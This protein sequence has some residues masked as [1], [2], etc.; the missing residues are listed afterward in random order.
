MRQK[1]IYGKKKKNKFFI[2]ILM[3]ILILLV[4]ILGGILYY[5]SLIG[6]ADANGQ[7][8]I[9]EIPQ[10]YSVRAIASI[11][12]EE[13]IV[14]KDFAFLM[15]ARLG[16]VQSQLQSGKYLLSPSMSTEEIIDRLVGGDVVDERI[17]VTI[18]EGFELKMIAE[19]LEEK[20]LTN[21]EDFIQATQ[22]IDEFEYFFL[23]D[24]PKNRD[25]PLEGYLFPDTYYFSIDT[26]DQQMVRAMLDRFKD[27]FKEEY[28]ERA[29]ELGMSIDEIVILASV[30]EREAMVAADRPI[31]SG[32]FHKRLE[33]GMR[34]ESCATIQYIL[35]ERK[36][37]LLYSDLKVE[38]PY[39]T[40]KQTGLP[41]GPI[42]S[43]GEA[44]LKAT[45]YPDKTDY[46]FFVA[47]DDG[48]H[49]FTKT[50][51]EHNAAKKQVLN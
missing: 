38:S 36:P 20:G 33:I 19:R 40:Y 35:G 29:K 8:K 21:Q 32:V 31:I 46:L 13:D 45:L 41:I 50:L 17:K 51:Q 49:V 34:L 15:A 39:N 44:S 24:L 43:F 2:F 30:V 47:R 12:E 26:S 25:N 7:E 10:G 23:E 16:K 3:V 9:V 27:A 48:S 6:P 11:L 14:K 5:N 42:A 4:T 28:I 18:P 1:N 37:R 22:N